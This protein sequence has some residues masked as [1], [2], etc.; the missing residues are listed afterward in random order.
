M[1]QALTILNTPVRIHNSLYSLNDLH[2]ASGAEEKHR[3]SL[4]LR[5]DQTKSLIAEI[6]Q[7]TDMCFAPVQAVRGGAGGSST[8]A[9]REL[10]YAYAM[11][12]S[13]R[14]HLTVIRAFDALV[15]PPGRTISPA[16]AGELATLVAHR[17]GDQGKPRAYYWSRFNN[18]FHIARYRELPADRFDEAVEYLKT[19]PDEH[20][21]PP[22]TI[23][24]RTRLLVTIEGNRIIHSAD[25]SDCSLVDTRGLATLRRNLA[26]ISQQLKWLTGEESAET[27]DKPLENLR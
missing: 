15:N 9:C 5:T 25:A 10:V 7:S 12:I 27:I 13:A 20:G 2:K 16:Q 8:Y 22:R 21:N 19:M 18:H 14:F 17:A 24:G 11:W 4:W 6:E 23:A 26:T 1:T 3:P